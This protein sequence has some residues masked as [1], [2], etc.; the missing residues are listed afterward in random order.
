MPA[1]WDRTQELAQIRRHLGRA[2]F[3]YVT[4]RRRVG[5]TALLAQAVA[6]FGG[7]YHQA[8]EG[9]PQQQLLH[10]AE[11]VR[12]VWPIF[13][14]V[15]PK[16][17]SEC[18]R[19]LA[20]ERLPPLVVF[21]EFPYWVAADPGLPSLFQ[22][23]IDHELP[24]HRTLL[25]VSG[26]SQSM[27]HAQFL[28][29]AAPLY[30]RASFHI[31]LMPLTVSWFCRALGYPARR[32]ESFARFAVVG[33]IPHYWRVMPRG[34]CVRQVEALYFEPGAV[35]AE[36]PTALIRD[37][38]IAGALPKGI[39]DLVGRGV[40]KPSELASR[41]GVAQGNLSRPLALLLETGLIHRELPFGESP[42][43]TKRVLYSIQD[44]A[45]AFYHSVYLPHRSRWGGLSPSEKT[46]ILRQHTAR[47]WE[48]FC[49]RVHSGSA[50]YW[51]RD[52]ELDV[53]W[54]QGSRRLVVAECKW[55]SL[56][57][58]KG[59]ALLQDLRGRFLRTAL[60][61]RFKQVEFRLWTQKD[62]PALA[63]RES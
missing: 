4:G 55:A 12:D 59:Q 46:R 27:L 11:E 44:P 58:A 61:R 39:L 63:A 45:L 17:W 35:L 10:L 47:Q 53:V 31:R 13:R 20:R 54:E 22:K 16:N 48:H 15:T 36:E 24:K 3:G 28:H 14:D 26:S 56:T 7:I 37:E 5:K 29:Q 9:T 40:A 32:P 62:W 1:F 52:V 30:G 2:G 41:L 25:L 43:T 57:S 34:S 6:R 21:D 8:V 23:W 49:R 38:G 50:R 51:E 42:R 33:G 19:L 18:F 60:S